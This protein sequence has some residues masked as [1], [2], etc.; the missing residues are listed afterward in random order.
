MQTLF[1]RL[2]PG[3]NKH[4]K[5]KPVLR[6]LLAVVPGGLWA[7][8]D[9]STTGSECVI[10]ALPSGALIPPNAG[11]YLGVAGNLVVYSACFPTME[12]V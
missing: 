4:G 9:E 7:E 12:K 8:A 2:V 6:R 3:A 1:V 10:Y 11:P 5:S